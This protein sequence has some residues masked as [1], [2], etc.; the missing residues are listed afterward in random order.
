MKLNLIVL[1]IFLVC[2]FCT[3]ILLGQE[4]VKVKYTETVFFDNTVNLP[5][6]AMANMP[7]SRDNKK[8]LM[9]NDSSSIYIINK[10]DVEAEPQ[11]DSE[12]RR[13][14][15]RRPGVNTTIYNNI[16]TNEQFTFTDLFGKEFLIAESPVSKWKLHSGEQ[17]DILGHVCVK[18]TQLKDTTL[19]TAWFT[20]DIPYS[21]GP[22]GYTGLPGLILA[23]S[24][25]ESKVILA[26]HIEE[27]VQLNT[28]IE[29]PNKG[30]IVTREEYEK[31]R[32]QKLEEM[33]E[34]WG[35]QGSHQRM[36]NRN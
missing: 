18:A 17:R 26:T 9:A 22:D 6:Q 21:F 10:E 13:W 16:N 11:G 3:L 30:E 14:R 7:K 25:G 31:I 15:N 2:S 5:P 12:G 36:M 24:V 29:R 28:I 1:P 4:N 23:L 27:N 19:T 34:M 33:K 32:K 20:S 35:G 8:I